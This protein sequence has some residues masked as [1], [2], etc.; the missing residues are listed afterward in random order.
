M[1]VRISGSG[2]KGWKRMD[3]TIE[4][5]VQNV[6][7]KGIQKTTQTTIQVLRNRKDKGDHDIAGA[8]LGLM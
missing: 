2:L 3:K 1:R 7:L 8:F 4:A 6:E 5:T